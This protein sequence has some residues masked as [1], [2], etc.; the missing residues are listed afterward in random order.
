MPPYADGFS[1]AGTNGWVGNEDAAVIS[2]DSALIDA[3]GDFV[4]A[5]NL[6]PIPEAPHTK[7]LCIAE[8]EIPRG[9]AREPKEISNRINGNTSTVFTDLLW[10]PRRGT[11]PHVTTNHQ[12]AFYPHLN[13]A[14]IIWHE[15]SGSNEWHRLTNAPI[16]ST[17]EWVRV[18]VEQNFTH[19][20]WRIRVNG[21]E[22]IS[23]AKGW[24]TAAGTIQPGA[25]FNMVQKGGSMKR[26]EFE[27][28][29]CIDDLVVKR[30]NPFP[31]GLLLIIR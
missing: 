14:L 31:D 24:N 9:R 11:E 8:D 5:G 13:G 16:L 30:T 7:V 21:Q 3:I 2:T 4:N 10:F 28:E 26:I 12:F 23:D 20:R 17:G 22:H 19:S 29:S 15:Y 18:T 27:G 1:I 6:L 25:W